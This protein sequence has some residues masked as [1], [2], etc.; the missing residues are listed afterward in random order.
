MAPLPPI[1]TPLNQHS[2][3]D[4]ELWL[5]N[6][7]A[8]KSN[9]DPCLWDWTTPSWTA[10]IKIDVK[11]LRITWNK[12]GEKYKY[13]FPYGLTREDIQLAFDQGP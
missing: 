12:N 1:K 6:L 8:H 11:E 2:L 7:G 10:Q 9:I 13:N 3:E 4:I 5:G